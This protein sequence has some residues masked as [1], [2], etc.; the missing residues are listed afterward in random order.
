MKEKFNEF[1][2]KSTDIFRGIGESTSV[3]VPV[4]GSPL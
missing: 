2:N 3:M 1:P 4:G